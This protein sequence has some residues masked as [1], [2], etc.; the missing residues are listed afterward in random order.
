MLVLVHQLLQ[1]LLL[2]LQ[3]HLLLL[4]LVCEC[5]GRVE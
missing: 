1:A 4:V 2:P 5:S 3:H